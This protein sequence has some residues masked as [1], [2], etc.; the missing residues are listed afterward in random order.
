M[1]LRIPTAVPCYQGLSCN[2]LIYINLQQRR[3]YQPL[4]LGTKAMESLRF[5]PSI[6]LGHNLLEKH[7]FS[8]IKA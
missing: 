8:F 3:G 2:M 1:L 4:N 5:S 6:V 7:G